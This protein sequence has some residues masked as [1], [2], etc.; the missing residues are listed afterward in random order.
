M[1]MVDSAS[2]WDG[3]ADKYSR[4]PIRDM[5]SYEETLAC[6]RQ[7]L[8]PDDRV[9]ELGCGTGTTALKLAPYLREIVA[10]DFAQ[11]M[12]EIARE[13]A[14]A[15]GVANARFE[16]GSFF[17]PHRPAGSFDAVLAFNVL[18]LLEDLP[19]ALGRVREVLKPGGVF[20]SKS[21]CLAEQTRLWRVPIRI[22][23]WIGRAPYVTCM[24]VSELE[25]AIAG[26]GFEIVDARFFGSSLPSRFVV[27]RA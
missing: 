14:A 6:T 15:Q 17:D 22:M 11:R 26:A 23:Q 9:L 7:H 24:R 12:V 20:V 18:H 1:T 8:S 10:V 16:C 3:T 13:K 5:E 25:A 27:A 21:V 2:F 19:A 4:Q